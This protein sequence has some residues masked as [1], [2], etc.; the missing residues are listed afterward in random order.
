MPRRSASMPA[1]AFQTPRVASVR[2]ISPAMAPLA[3]I[4]RFRPGSL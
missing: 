1:G 2:A 4:V 3:P